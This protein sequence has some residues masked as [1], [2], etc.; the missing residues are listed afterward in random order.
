MNTLIDQPPWDEGSVTL[1]LIR[2]GRL[3]LGMGAP[4]GGLLYL[5]ACGDGWVRL[6]TKQDGPEVPVRVTKKR[7]ITIVFEFRRRARFRDGGQLV[8][9]ARDVRG[10]QEF[11][12]FAPHAL[13]SRGWTGRNWPTAG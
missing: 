5:T 3:T 12:L 2:R 8:V 9:L 11:T 10:Q 7:R 4:Q 6:A 13:T 1:T